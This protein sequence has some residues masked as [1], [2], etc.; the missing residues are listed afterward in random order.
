MADR[1]A[2]EI[3]IGGNLPRSLLG[4]F[5][6]SDLSLDWDITPCDATSEEGVLKPVTKTVCC[7]LPTAKRRMGSSRN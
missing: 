6:I 1:M 2:A 3:W 4:E 5:P 7:I